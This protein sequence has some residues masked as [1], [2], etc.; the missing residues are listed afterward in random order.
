MDGTLI[1][2]GSGLVGLNILDF[3]MTWKGIHKLGAKEVNPMMDFLL[4]L[5]YK[6]SLAFKTIFPA[7]IAVMFILK[8]NQS[9]LVIA[10]CIFG[11]LCLWNFFVMRRKMKKITA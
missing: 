9:S 1:A 4:K 11:G 2:L 8:G 7:V 6:P 10:N 5:G 3:K